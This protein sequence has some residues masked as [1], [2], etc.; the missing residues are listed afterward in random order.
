M[1]VHADPCPYTEKRGG[2]THIA[3]LVLTFAL[4][5]PLSSGN[6]SSNK[7]NKTAKPYAGVAVHC[8]YVLNLA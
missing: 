7:R 4:V 1:Y 6:L 8:V 3:P 2:S 5:Y